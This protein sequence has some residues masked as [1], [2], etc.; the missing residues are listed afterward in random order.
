[1][2]SAVVQERVGEKAGATLLWPLLAIGVCSLLLWRWTGDLRLYAWAQFFP[3]TALVIILSLFPPK[4]TGS[5]Y[6]VA[7]AALYALA[8]LL[9]H[10]DH[11]VYS[12]GGALSGHTLKHLAAAAACFAI[13]RAFQ[14]R[15]PLSAVGG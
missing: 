6:W 2:L 3:L 13:L 1:M 11:Q 10:F 15:Q 4:Y 9:E 12:F 14:L 7:A 5:R 8:K